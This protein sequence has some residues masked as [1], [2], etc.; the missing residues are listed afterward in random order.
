MSESF[1]PNFPTL[2]IQTTYAI[3]NIKNYLKFPPKPHITISHTSNIENFQLN[4]QQNNFNLTKIFPNQ[5]P[6]LNHNYL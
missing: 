1:A 4:R 2:K 5:Y 6:I 3:S